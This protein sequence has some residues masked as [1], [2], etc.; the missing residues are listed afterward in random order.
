MDSLPI[1]AIFLQSD[2]EFPAPGTDNSGEAWIY[3]PLSEWREGYPY[4]NQL[5]IWACRQI[6]DCYTMMARTKLTVGQPYPGDE[7]FLPSELRPE[8]RFSVVKRDQE[9]QI[10]DALV[11]EQFTLDATLLKESHFNIV[12]WYAVTRTKSLHMDK[13]EASQHDGLMGQAVM[14]SND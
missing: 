7:H 9:Y 1:G 6:G 11:D 4:W 5:D 12:H 2:D 10:S 3:R 14:T 8:V 13:D